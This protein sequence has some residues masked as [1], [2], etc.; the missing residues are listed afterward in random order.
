VLNLI[1]TDRGWI[2]VEPQTGAM[3]ELSK[4]PNL[5]HIIGIAFG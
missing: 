4:Y 3:V 2:V 1:G 5:K